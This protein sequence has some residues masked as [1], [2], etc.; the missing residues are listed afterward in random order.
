M[1]LEANEG[2]NETFNERYTSFWPSFVHFLLAHAFV[3]LQADLLLGHK[4]NVDPE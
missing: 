2:M 1:R 4:D 3:A